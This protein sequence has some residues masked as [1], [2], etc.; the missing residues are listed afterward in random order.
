M[1]P[2]PKGFYRLLGVDP[3]APAAVIVAAFRRKARLLHPD[4]PITGDAESFIELK[5][6]YDALSDPIR[7]LDY[8]RTARREVEPARTRARQSWRA[9]RISRNRCRNGSGDRI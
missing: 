4:V 7:R 5:Q 8:D 1:D 3:A 9:T 2:D 6:A